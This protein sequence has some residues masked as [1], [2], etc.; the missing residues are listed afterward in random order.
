M[1]KARAAKGAP[2]APADVDR[3]LVDWRTLNKDVLQLSEEAV[4]HLLEVAVQR[5]T[6][7]QVVLRLHARFNRLRAERERSEVLRGVVSWR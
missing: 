6:R 2:L 5:G 4:R 1:A 7:A 3:L